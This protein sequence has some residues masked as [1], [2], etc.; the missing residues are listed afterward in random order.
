MIRCGPVVMTADSTSGFAWLL[1][2]CVAS[3]KAV[4]GTSATKRPLVTTSEG[5]GIS[6][7]FQGYILLQYDPS[8]WKLPKQF[9]SSF[10]LFGEFSSKF[11]DDICT[12]G[13]L[14]K[15]NSSPV[16][17]FEYDIKKKLGKGQPP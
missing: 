14:R 7:W 6:S 10:S 13:W 11:S 17:I 1:C 4:C 9:L 3:C 5:K 8:C 2:K 16:F 15:R 12:S